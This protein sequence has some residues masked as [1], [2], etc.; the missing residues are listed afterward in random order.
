MKALFGRGGL[1]CFAK[2]YSTGIGWNHFIY[3]TLRYPNSL[4]EVSSLDVWNIR[5]D[6]T[7]AYATVTS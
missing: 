2:D 5:F 7:K 4:H 1:E 6:S 3:P